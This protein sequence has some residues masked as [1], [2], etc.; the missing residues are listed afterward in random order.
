MLPSIL[1][2][3]KA[4]IHSKKK[5]QSYKTVGGV[6]F[7]AD[8]ALLTS[9]WNK[10]KREG[11]RKKRRKKLNTCTHL[12]TPLSGNVVQASSVVAH[13]LSIRVS[14]GRRKKE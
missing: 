5:K 2:S 8:W 12:L 4:N 11:A 7:K 9:K 6:L 1:V 14:V 13:R 3:E 10:N